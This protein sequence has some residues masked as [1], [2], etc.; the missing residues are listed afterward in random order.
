M[1]SSI[2][3]DLSPLELAVLIPCF[4]EEASIGTVVRD[5]REVLPEATIYVYDNNSTD[6]TVE[7]ALAAGAIIGTELLQGKGNVVRRM[8]A[9][10]D[11]DVFILVDGDG[12]Y[13]ASS[14]PLMLKEL[15][16]S[17]LDMVNAAR[18]GLS[19]AAYRT[20]HRMGNILL[21]LM[22]AFI[23]GNRIHDMLSGYRCFSRR[24]V[25]SF[26]AL[27][28]G[29]EIETELTV[30]AL[31]LRMPVAEIATPYK[32]RP[33]GSTS[34]LSALR[35]G[36]RILSTIAALV[37]EDRP[38]LF[39]GVFFLLLATGSIVLAW[40][41]AIT[42]LETGLVPRF[43]TAILATGMMLLAFLSGTCGLILDTVTRGRLEI[44]RFHYLA[45]PPPNRQFSKTA[46]TK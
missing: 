28:R 26:P 18:K 33:A 12:T 43:P 11:A 44:K 4:N 27:T 45:I 6:A 22:V 7:R 38:L 35:D 37:R 8:F 1:R 34:K 30:H 36:F 5:F 13:D 3:R 39:F 42:Y 14:A 21:T 23:F 41:L 10:I 25:K 9:D 15:V 40:P 19:T 46:P 24:F 32:E 2:H 20:G 31:E 16:E 17:S 29:F